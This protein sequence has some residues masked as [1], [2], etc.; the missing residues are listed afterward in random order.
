MATFHA[1]Q[2]T[3]EAVRQLLAGAFRPDLLEPPI[4]LQFEIYSTDDFRAAMPAGVSLF[5]Y[6]VHINAV[7]RRPLE[8]RDDGTFGRPQLPLDL[9]FF[10]TV[11]G[12]RA[13]SEASVRAEGEAAASGARNQAALLAGGAPAEVAA[14]EGG[15]R[16]LDAGG[17]AAPGVPAG[18]EPAGGTAEEA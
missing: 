1:I 8:R 13:S 14:A 12:R 4:E 2:A 7:Q 3:C 10:L 5:L 17:A 11:W 9:H 15:A 18:P 6:R 16:A